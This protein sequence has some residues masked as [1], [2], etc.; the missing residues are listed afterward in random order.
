MFFV[1]ALLFLITLPFRIL[2]TIIGG[3]LRVTGG[4]IILVNGFLGNILRFIGLVLILFDVVGSLFCV[5]NFHGAGEALPNW[6]IYSLATI[7]IGVFLTL[8]ANFGDWLGN[9]FADWG[10][11]LLRFSWQMPIL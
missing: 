5:F 2:G 4:L 11:G 1:Y 9:H 8:I 3:T 7:G 6:W 10:D